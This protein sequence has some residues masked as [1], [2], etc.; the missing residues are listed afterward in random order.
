MEVGDAVVDVRV[1]AWLMAPDAC[2]AASVSDSPEQ[3]AKARA[4]APLARLH[5]VLFG[6]YPCTQ[7][8]RRVR[9]P[10]AGLHRVLSG[11]YPCTQDAKARAPPLAR[12][13]RVLSGSYTCTQDAKAR[14]PPLA[15][16]PQHSRM[17][18]R[19]TG[20]GSAD[21][22]SQQACRRACRDHAG[23]GIMPR[24]RGCAAVASCEPDQRRGS[25]MA[26]TMRERRAARAQARKA[27]AV[28]G[29]L[30]RVN[31]RARDDAAAAARLGRDALGGRA[32]ACLACARAA[33]AWALYQHQRPQLEVRITLACPCA[34][35]HAA[36]PICGVRSCS[37]MSGLAERHCRCGQ[38]VTCARRHRV[39]D[40]LHP[41][42]V[43]G[44]VA[45]ACIP[46]EVTWPAARPCDNFVLYSYKLLHCTLGTSRQQR[47]GG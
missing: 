36:C 40:A 24:R 22:G 14:A 21:G 5:R 19:C 15:L 32:E 35:S 18:K 13:R 37:A 11:S 43:E 8:P 27:T 42:S 2:G 6:S 9:A 28:E 17:P 38:G 26:R 34:G 1:A 47:S 30:G 39:Q 12:L 41:C 3:D 44:F 20:E 45:H 23:R 31:A 4:P 25:C 16:S 33:M 46:D 7:D 29:L 10:L